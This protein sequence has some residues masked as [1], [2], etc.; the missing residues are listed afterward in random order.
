MILRFRLGW[1]FKINLIFIFIFIILKD[2]LTIL[3]KVA[4]IIIRIIIFLICNTFFFVIN[5][6]F[7]RVVR[8]VFLFHFV[9]GLLI[10]IILLSV[11]AVFIIAST[12][13]TLSFSSCDCLVLLLHL[14]YIVVHVG[15]VILVHFH[16]HTVVQVVNNLLLI[17]VKVLRL[18]LSVLEVCSWVVL[19]FI[20]YVN[21]LKVFIVF[22]KVFIQEFILSFFIF[23]FIF[24]FPSSLSAL[25]ACFFGLFAILVSLF[26]VYSA[27]I[28]H[29]RHG[30]IQHAFRT[31]SSSCRWRL[32]GRCTR[33]RHADILERPTSCLLVVCCLSIDLLSLLNIIR[34]LYHIAI[35]TVFSSLDVVDLLNWFAYDLIHQR[36]G[37]HSRRLHITNLESR[38][39]K[40]SDDLISESLLIFC[41]RW[42]HDVCGYIVH[43]ICYI[44]LLEASLLCYFSGLVKSDLLI[45]ELLLLLLHSGHFLSEFL[46]LLLR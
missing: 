29:S 40:C 15:D 27:L 46:L 44:L 28:M 35:T 10:V 1:L 24:M 21:L 12:V 43:Q 23:V 37:N 6:I 11:F 8:D 25:S 13:L 33:W 26:A 19:G 39:T 36:L 38:R 30:R 9:G 16:F 20:C 5:I 42:I 45:E 18:N 32:L 3:V 17:I 31:F 34:T 2:L 14:H 41:H 7:I 22:I 4:Y